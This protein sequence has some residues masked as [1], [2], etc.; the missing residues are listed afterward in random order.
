MNTKAIEIGK[1]LKTFRKSL[2]CTLAEMEKLSGLKSSTISEMESGRNKPN[3]QYLLFLYETYKLNITWIFTG[4]GSMI[5]PDLQLTFNFGI[6][7]DRIIEMIDK[8]E[9]DEVIRHKLLLYYLEN[10]GGKSLK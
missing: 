6:D 7:T 2:S 1:R 8:I 3:T 4:R 10:C 9:N 5:L